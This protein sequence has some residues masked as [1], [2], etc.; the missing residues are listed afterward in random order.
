[1]RPVR[2]VDDLPLPPGQRPASW[3]PVHYGRVPRLDEERWSLTVG[4]ETFD[5]GMTVLDRA[6]LHALPWTEVVAR[7]HC[8]A[9]TSTPPLRWGGV[10]MA[11]VVAVAPPAADAGHVL[12]AAARGYAACVTLADLVHADSLLATHV[13]GQPLTPEQGWP[14]RVVLP[15]LYGFKGPKWVAELT[16][17]RRP[18]QGWWE[19]HGY[20][21]RARVAHEERFAHQD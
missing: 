10:R 2:T 3:R 1:M 13:D 8:V 21:P 7:L 11:D 16:Y 4:G 17:H 19:S 6:A 18:Q 12:L 5:G 14:G 9:R 15:H 20:H